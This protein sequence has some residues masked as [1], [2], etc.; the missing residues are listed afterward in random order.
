[1]WTVVDSF[2]R[3]H[4]D[5]TTINKDVYLFFPL[6]RRH[7]QERMYPA[8]ATGTSPAR[9]CPPTFSSTAAAAAAAAAAS[10]TTILTAT[11]KYQ[12]RDMGSAERNNKNG[13]LSDPPSGG[14]GCSATARSAIKRPSAREEK[15]NK[16][17]V[18]T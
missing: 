11:T 1:M 8:D 17:A 6:G 4:M 3:I 5:D 12:P 9:F 18:V 10:S 13:S 14:G 16:L 7:E 15:E 2:F